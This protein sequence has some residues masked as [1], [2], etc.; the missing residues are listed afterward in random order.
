MIKKLKNTTGATR[1]Y[2]GEEIQAGTYYEVQRQEWDLW[3]SNPDI[4]TDL[5]NGDLVFNDGTSDYPVA[6]DG[7]EMWHAVDATCLRG[8]VFDD[9]GIGDKC[10]PCYDQGQNKLKYANHDGIDGSGTNTHAQIDSHLASTSNPHSVT[11]SQVGLGNVDN[12]SDA[13]K[14]VSTAQQT[15]LDAKVDDSEK[16]AANGVATLDGTGKVPSSQLNITSMTYKG[17]WNA[18]TNTPTLSDSGGGGAQG[19]YYVI[20]TAGTTT[21]DGISSWAVGDWIVNNGSVW[22][23]VDNTEQVTSVAGKQGAVILD[24]DDVSETASKKWLSSTDKTKLDGIE[25]GATADQTDAEI[26]T[27]YENNANTNAFTDSDQTKLGHI[28]VTQP[29]NLDTMESD[30]TANNAKVTNA[31]HTGDVTG[32]GSL[33]VDPTAIT[34]KSLVTAASGDQ[35]LIAD[36]SDGN[37][38]KKVDVSDFMAGGS[39][40]NVSENF[41]KVSHGFLVGDVVRHSGIN[42]EDWVKA[43]A[44]T[45]ANS[46]A[47]GLISAVSGNDFTVCYSGKVSG[48]SGLTNDEIH[49]LSDSVAGGL[50]TTEPSISKPILYAP[51]TSTAIVM[52]QRGMTGDSSE[53]FPGLFFYADNFD[54][55]NNADWAVNALA[56]A[57][58]DSNNNALSIRAFDDTT[59]EG[60]GF[61][62]MIPLGKTNMDITFKSR[63]EVAPAGARTV[64]LKLYNRS[65]GN[66]T[67]VGAWSAGNALADI[68]IPINESFQYDTDTITLASLGATAGELHQFQLTRINPSAGTE[69]TGDW[70]LLE[71]KIEFS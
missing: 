63:A 62:V 19:D 8:K 7:L 43:Q 69:L 10:V 18:N 68:D 30:I 14:P 5:T 60:V 36:S 9:T 65:V 31:T 67:A 42:P 20:D 71:M 28:N 51:S 41:T 50:T 32:S 2:H 48:L 11:K 55:P 59:E 58:A 1:T 39:S 27:A 57:Q 26:K 25:S 12:T 66:N 64:G 33:T 53:S 3:Q 16:G 34:G 13:S 54:N 38:L 70:N 35:V 46:E 22:E 24:A 37:N 6:A 61:M 17:T 40:S 44:D 4:D 21:I 47:M 45:A 49:F 52:I 23:K 29:V 56:P 15:A